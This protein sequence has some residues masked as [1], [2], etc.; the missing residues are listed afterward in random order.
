MKILST[1]RDGPRLGPHQGASGMQGKAGDPRRGGKGMDCKPSAA[2][3]RIAA[4]NQ[5]PRLHTQQR[6]VLSYPLGPDAAPHSSDWRTCNPTMHC[7]SRH[8]RRRRGATSR[9]DAPLSIAPP[10]IRIE[11]RLLPGL[12]LTD[13]LQLPGVRQLLPPPQGGCCGGNFAVHD[14]PCWASPCGPRPRRGG[15]TRP[16]AI[17][18]ISVDRAMPVVS[19]ASESGL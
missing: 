4:A 6:A 2:E 12:F 9:A 3:A 8:G 10:P 18:R 15:I 11:L 13:G 1:R 5:L 19:A 16:D 7:V 17:Q 14:T